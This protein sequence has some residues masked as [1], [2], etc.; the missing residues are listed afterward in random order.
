METGLFGYK[1]DIAIVQSIAIQVHPVYFEDADEDVAGSQPSAR[2][3][4]SGQGKL[5][6]YASRSVIQPG[7]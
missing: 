2:R 3:S 4:F 7:V 1:I 5:Y 6:L